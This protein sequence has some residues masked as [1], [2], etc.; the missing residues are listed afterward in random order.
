MCEVRTLYNVYVCMYMF[1]CMYMRRPTQR[2]RERETEVE[3][4][5]MLDIKTRE[6][7]DIA[8]FKN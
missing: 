8:P 2:E 7:R 6:N 5:L 3:F 4:F 1:V